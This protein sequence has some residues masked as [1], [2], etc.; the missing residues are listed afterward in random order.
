M[1]IEKRRPA[2]HGLRTSTKKRRVYEN[3]PQKA[4]RIS[5]AFHRENS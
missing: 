4:N 2:I 5:N 3:E 1:L